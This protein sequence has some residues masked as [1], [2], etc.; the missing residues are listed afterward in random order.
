VIF[1]FHPYLKQKTKNA[2]EYLGM[3][4]TAQLAPT[5]ELLRRIQNPSLR[6]NKLIEIIESM[7]ALKVNLRMGIE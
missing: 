1:G 6:F 5:H 3:L 4:K 2:K 7:I